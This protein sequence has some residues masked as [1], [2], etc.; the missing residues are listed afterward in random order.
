MQMRLVV[1]IVGSQGFSMR[2]DLFEGCLCW[3]VVMLKHLAVP[4]G[5]T[6]D[7]PFL[8]IWVMC[9]ILVLFYFTFFISG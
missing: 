5:K 4:G 3:R 6:T 1:P 2:I 7:F 9:S 8:S